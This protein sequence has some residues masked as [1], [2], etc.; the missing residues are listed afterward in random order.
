MLKRK[1]AA[2]TITKQKNDKKINTNNQK[3]GKHSD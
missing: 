1:F 2:M 3:I